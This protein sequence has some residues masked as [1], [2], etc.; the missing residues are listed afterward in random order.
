MLLRINPDNPQERLLQQAVDVLRQGGIVIYPTDTVY[1]I[2]CDIA[3]KKAVEKVAR[4]KG[5]DP[6][7]A[8][9]ACICPD[10]SIL[11]DYAAQVTT[12]EYKLLRHALPG[13]YTFILRASKNVPRHFQ[14]SKK[15][16]GLR[17][18]DHKIPV[19]LSSMLGNPL[20]TTSLKDDD[21]VLEY[22]TDPELIHERYS[23]QGVDVV[24][25]G[26]YGGNEP[27]TIL[28]LSG[29]LENLT[30]IREGK[31]S[32]EALNLSLESE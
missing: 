30:V 22:T 5:Q 31:G 1:G 24:I 4:L 6:G 29:G 20:L 16:V 25:D 19:S 7:K 28:D 21:E 2:G 17:I 13:P 9:F 15:T 12:P 26:G 27:S 32:L 18:P 23:N 8:N 14:S 11:S 10:L 3:N